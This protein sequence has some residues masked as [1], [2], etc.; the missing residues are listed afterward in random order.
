LMYIIRPIRRLRF[1]GTG[2]F[3][4]YDWPNENYPTGIATGRLLTTMYTTPML[5]SYNTRL[6]Q[7][8]TQRLQRP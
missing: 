1:V 8:P 4:R 7:G 3:G 6:V 2:Y 5:P